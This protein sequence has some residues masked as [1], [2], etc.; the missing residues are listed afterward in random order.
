MT[1]GLRKEGELAIVESRSKE[2]SALPVAS[3]INERQMASGDSAR[4]ILEG[5]ISVVTTKHS[6]TFKVENTFG[7]ISLGDS[8]TPQ[9]NPF[10]TSFSLAPGTI[11]EDLIK[12]QR[13]R[14]ELQNSPKGPMAINVSKVDEAPETTPLQEKK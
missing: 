1:D 7:Y 9:G 11:A 13:V 12:G 3:E 10:F 4:A 5:V 2:K 14:F 6:P 8:G